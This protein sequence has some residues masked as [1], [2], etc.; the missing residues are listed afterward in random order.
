[1]HL[2]DEDDMKKPLGSSVINLANTSS[3]AKEYYY[4]TN[5]LNTI[6]KKIYVEFW[7][8]FMCQ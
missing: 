7:K 2:V 3:G 4:Y 6:E 5:Q 8:F 1:M